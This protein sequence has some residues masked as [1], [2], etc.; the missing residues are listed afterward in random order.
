MYAARGGQEADEI[1]D[2]LRLGSPSEQCCLG[3]GVEQFA[4]GCVGVDGAW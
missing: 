3:A 2:L 4:I 1:S